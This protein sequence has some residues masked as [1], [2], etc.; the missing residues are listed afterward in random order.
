M[1]SWQ[2]LFGWGR[3]GY[4]KPRGVIVSENMHYYYYFFHSE[5]SRKRAQRLGGVEGKS[6]NDIF[7][8]RMVWG[9]DRNYLSILSSSLFSNP[10][11]T[12]DGFANRMETEL[13]LILDEVAPLKTGHRTGTRKAKN[14]LSPEAV[15]AKKQRRIGSSGD[16]R[17][18]TPS[19]TAS[20]IG[21]LARLQTS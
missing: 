14:W 9:V 11:P 18:P 15:D 20:P 10:N 3:G 2:K 8:Q 13:T 4:K 12:V 17:L 5:E 6:A 19:L 1:G 16:G 21:L 7:V